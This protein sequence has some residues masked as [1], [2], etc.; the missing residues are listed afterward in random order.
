MFSPK[1]H[2]T[3]MSF[4]QEND[5]ALYA[6]ESGAI[7]GVLKQ[8]KEGFETNMADSQAEENQAIDEFNSMKKAKTDQIKAAEDLSSSKTVELGDTKAKLAADKQDLK[9]TKA[10]LAADTEFLGTVTEQC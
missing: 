10:Q 4:V 7:F 2:K 3:I 9:D 6:P 5:A 8:M 1:Q